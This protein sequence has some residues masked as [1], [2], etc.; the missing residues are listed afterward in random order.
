MSNI[1]TDQEAL[2]LCS[3]REA[4]DQGDDGMRAVQH[5]IMNRVG[6]PGFG[7]TIQECIFGRNQFSSMSISTD[8]DFHRNPEPGDPQY[9]FCL[10]LAENIA[11]DPDLT[12][13][14]LWYANLRNVTSGWFER[15]ISG[16]DGTGTADHPVLAKIG[17]HTF[18]A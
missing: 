6:K 7:K 13:G 12:N 2:A 10:T 4:S 15:V 8:P 18:F 11:T 5:I 14:A 16:P 3:W 1:D 17:S 9:A